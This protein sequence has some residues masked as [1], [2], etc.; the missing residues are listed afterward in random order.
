ML[1]KIKKNEQGFTFVEILVCLAIVS[2]VVGPICF[3]FVS[4]LKTRVTAES[5]DKVTANTEKLLE[6]IKAQMADDI[7]LRQKIIGN[8]VP[9]ASYSSAADISIARNGV[10]NYLEDISSTGSPRPGVQMNTFLKGT[11]S[12]QLSARYNTNDYAYEVALWKID[13]VPFVSTAEGKTLTLNQTTIDKA[14][15]LYTDS[16]VAYQFNPSSYTGIA[17]PIKFQLS[18]AM[19]KTFED[20]NLTYVPTQ[21]AADVGYKMIDKNTITIETN[22]LSTTPDLSKVANWRIKSGTGVQEAI[23]ISKI[24]PIKTGGT[25]VGYVFTIAE[26]PEAAAFATNTSHYRGI[27]ELDVRKLLRK[28]SNLGAEI[29]YDHL[30]FKVINT[31][32]YDQLITVRQNVAETETV[33]TINNKFN[34]VLENTGI[35]KSSL[36]R[37]DDINAYQNYIIAVIAREKNPVLGEP[38]KIVKKAI[39]IFSYD[40]TTDQRR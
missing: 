15:K 4:S 20:Q 32:R 9:T 37:L 27:V 13:D 36:V 34:I 28:D 21:A 12:A 22:I 14:T 24:E 38:G 11:T 8:R 23:K 16:S 5:I 2:L 17:N 30:T 6:D 40:V 7:I 1:K 29:S 18:D 25:T 26:G 10:G 31:T 19:L 3:S 39:D 33:S 35:G